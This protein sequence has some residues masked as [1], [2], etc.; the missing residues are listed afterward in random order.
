[1]N[2]NSVYNLI[3]ISDLKTVG[4][5][6]ITGSSIT[7]GIGNEYKDGF[8]L[9]FSRIKEIGGFESVKVQNGAV[10]S[11]AGINT[12]YVSALKEE[13]L[14]KLGIKWVDA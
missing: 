5:A 2:N 11:V 1:M 6:T 10:L 3:N 12:P 7:F 13:S 4:T 14:L 9:M 8:F